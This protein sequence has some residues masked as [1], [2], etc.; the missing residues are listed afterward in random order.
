[1]LKTLMI[2][3]ARSLPSIVVCFIGVTAFKNGFKYFG[4][5]FN[6]QLWLVFLVLWSVG[7]LTGF[8]FGE[9]ANDIIPLFSILIFLIGI[10][11]LIV[12]LIFGPRKKTG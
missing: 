11:F 12:S 4:I 10:L 5:V 2:C 9:V 8:L 7:T 1:M 6:I 3:S